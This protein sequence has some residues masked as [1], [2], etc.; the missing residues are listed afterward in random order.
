MM[1]H[2]KLG[3]WDYKASQALYASVP[4]FRYTIPPVSTV[5]IHYRTELFSLVLLLA[6]GFVLFIVILQ[7]I[8]VMHQL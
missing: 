5:L 1:R 3:D 6:T 7:R 2:S 8:P 4:D